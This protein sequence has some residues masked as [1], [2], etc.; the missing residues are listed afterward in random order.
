MW[1]ARTSGGARPGSDP[2]HY[3]TI[4]RSVDRAITGNVG[5]SLLTFRASIPQEK[6]KACE[7]HSTFLAP[8]APT[9][10]PMTAV[11][12]SVVRHLADTKQYNAMARR[13]PNRTIRPDELGLSLGEE[14]GLG[15]N[16]VAVKPGRRCI[17]AH[18]CDA[19]TVIKKPAQPGDMAVPATEWWIH[20]TTSGKSALALRP[21]VRCPIV[22]SYRL[23]RP[24]PPSPATGVR[25][26]TGPTIRSKSA[27]A[28]GFP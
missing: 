6:T 5:K 1:V 14:H 23:N 25:A 16:R 26:A 3:R 18:D 24:Q 11:A 15:L 9:K 22:D 19:V 28:P 12:Q 27:F 13:P 20:S 7:R 2:G 4:S 17:G 21:D 8:P 10:K